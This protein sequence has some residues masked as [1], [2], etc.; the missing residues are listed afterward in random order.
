[1]KRA[2]AFVLLLA[3][4]TASQ[5]LPIE[6]AVEYRLSSL[7]ATIG[8]VSEQFL[9]SGD[10]YAINS[11]TRSEGVLKL[12]LDDSIT[13]KSHGRIDAGGLQ[14]LEFAQTRASKPA[15]DIHAT[16]DWD[17]GV[18][19]SRFAG[20]TREVALPK[21]TQ[22]RISV[23]YQFMALT[24]AN[25][26]EMNM[27]NGRKVERYTYR[28]VDEVRLSTPAGDFDTLHYARVT[29]SPTD[30]KAEVWLA[31]DRFHIPVRMIFDDPKGPKLEQVVLSLR[32]R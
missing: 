31:K 18:L 9:R 14:P 19:V 27:S 16:F 13:L 32:V 6:I 28:F 4:A 25:V 1:M 21:A 30:N 11:V 7:G 20:E 8:R 10:T 2:L 15:K 17:R 12:V 29:D 3:A 5:A 23:M 24:K 22:D 26:V